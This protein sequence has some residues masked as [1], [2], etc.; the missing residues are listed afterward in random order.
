MKK[1]LFLCFLFLLVGAPLAASNPEELLSAGRVDE[2][3]KVLKQRTDASANDA[4]AWHLLCRSYYAKE[5][6]DDA[7]AAAKHAVALKPDSSDYHLWLGRAYGEKAQSI[8]SWHWLTALSLAG[9]TRSEFEKAVQLDAGNV[10]A[11]SDLA[12]FYA[13]APG[14]VG[15]GKDKARREA[16]QLAS[17]DAAAAHWIKGLLA[18]KEKDM[19]AAEREY[20][21]A[22]EAG[23]GDGGRWLDLASFY[24]RAGRTQD[25]QHAIDKAVAAEKKRGEV[26]YDAAT[27]LYQSDQDLAAAAKLVR[28]YLRSENKV[29]EAPAF[30]AHYLLGN[31]LE[32][33]GEK[34]AAV[35]EYRA[36]LDLNSDFSDARNAL[37]RLSRP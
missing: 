22:V 32:R 18:E 33:Q 6:W 3:V 21:A 10:G 12:E 30:R 9:K 15:G 34:Q 1:A 11:R 27:I 8:S 37:Q 4:E 24:Q 13:E 7:I 17:R 35:A 26:F 23:K 28:D 14:I 19:P 5:R 2:A 20:L 29:E 36:A 25:M 31:I 16:E